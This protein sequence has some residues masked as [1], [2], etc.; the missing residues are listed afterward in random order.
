MAGRWSGWQNGDQ[1]WFVDAAR[2]ILDGSWRIYEF[3]PDF[4]I[5]AAPPLGFSYSYSP[6][7]TLVL[8]PFVGLADVLGGTP[9]AACVGGSDELVYRQIVFP[10]LVA[11]VLEMEE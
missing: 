7:L 5:I 8:A 3:R 10:L 1:L 9:L 6:L 2:H 11:D 4:S